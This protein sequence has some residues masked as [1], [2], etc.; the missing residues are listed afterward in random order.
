MEEFI[1]VVEV[2]KILGVCRAT[3]F[4]YMK[5]GVIKPI[6]LSTRKMI[7]DKSEII[8]FAKH[9]ITQEAK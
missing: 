8:N 4:H 3:V 7:F 1:N 9:G 6:Y 5:K 2:C